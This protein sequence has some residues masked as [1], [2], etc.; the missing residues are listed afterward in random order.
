MPAWQREGEEAVGLPA[1]RT[2]LAF[3]RRRCQLVVDG[4]RRLQEMDGDHVPCWLM[5]EEAIDHRLHES[6]HRPDTAKSSRPTAGSL[7]RLLCPAKQ[8]IWS[9]PWS[10][11][12]VLDL[13]RRRT[14]WAKVTPMAH[15]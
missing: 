8:A 12:Q 15:V 10:R 13:D 7:K 4:E 6:L 9:R 14:A 3:L 1:S 5:I 2:F 11:A